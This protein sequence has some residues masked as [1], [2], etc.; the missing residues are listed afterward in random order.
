WSRSPLRQASRGRP[1][2]W[3]PAKSLADCRMNLGDIATW[4]LDEGRP[5]VGGRVGCDQYARTARLRLGKGRVEGECLVARQLPPV[6]VRK[7][8]IGHEYRDVAER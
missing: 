1:R 5:P 8:A 4:E 7:M 2:A 6:G 3:L